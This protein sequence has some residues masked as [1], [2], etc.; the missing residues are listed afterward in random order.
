MKHSLRFGN[1]RHRPPSRDAPPIGCPAGAAAHRCG[2]CRQRPDATGQLFGFLWTSPCQ[3]SGWQAKIC[4]GPVIHNGDNFAATA[5]CAQKHDAAKNHCKSMHIHHNHQIHPQ[6]CEHHFHKPQVLE[7]APGLCIRLWPKSRASPT[8]TMGTNQAQPVDKRAGPW[9]IPRC[10]DMR[11]MPGTP[12]T[13]T[14]L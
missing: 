12:H 1:Q 8:R 11:L 4:T 3:L 7:E 14:S 13:A 10:R 5:V 9:P 6:A 2:A